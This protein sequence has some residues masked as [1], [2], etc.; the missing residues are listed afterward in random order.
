MEYVYSDYFKFCEEFNQ[1]QDTKLYEKLQ[2]K[3][4]NS[5]VTDKDYYFLTINPDPSKTNL[6]DLLKACSKAM[7]KR[8][9]TYYEYVIEQRGD[10]PETCGDKPHAHLIFNKGIKHCKVVLEMKNS[11]KNLCDCNDFHYFNLKN[12]STE[13]L[14]TCT[15]YILDRKAD[16]AKWAKQDMDILFR[17][18]HNLQKSYKS[19]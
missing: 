7:S 18:K 8:W 4:G 3:M 19:T 12:I 6:N 5:P 16:P 10:T 13:D 15:S 17:A 11:F 1:I 9:I 2:G 14:V